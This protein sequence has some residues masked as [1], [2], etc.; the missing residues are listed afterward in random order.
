M[1]G[2]KYLSELVD[3]STF[4]KNK[5]NI[6]KAPTG[7]GK[8]YFALKYIPSLVNNALHQM[9][10]LIDTINGKEQILKNY[11][12]TTEPW[13]W[14]KGIARGEIWFEP[15]G[16]VVIM[17]YAKFGYIL[18]NAPDIHKQFDYI[19][20]DELHSLIKFQN[21]SPKPN[22]HSIAKRGLEAAVEND[23]TVVIALSA[24]PDPVKKNFKAPYIEVPI[25]SKELIQYE[26]HE[27]C[28]YSNLKEL[29]PT[30][31]PEDIGICY[32][33][34]ISKMIQV[35]EL[36]RSLG[37]SPIAIWSISNSDHP[38]T[39]E[40]LS[41]RTSI[42]NTFTIPPQYNLLII[43]SSSETS[44]KIKSKV[45]YVIVHSTNSDTQVQV[46]G[47]VNSDLVRIYLLR[48]GNPVNLVVPEEYLGTKLFVEDKKKLCEILNIWD[49]RGRLCKWNTI[50]KLLIDHD[51]EIKEGRTKNLRYA[52]ITQS[53]K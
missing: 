29:F 15:D 6:I 33:S 10:Y 28:R 13:G 49:E 39:E 52:V 5:L 11:N 42:L 16:R 34:H 32:V 19:I 44:L 14:W 8:T 47:R 17:T 2:T 20:C 35:E 1:T 36:A 37:F 22:C 27:V 3:C 41:V 38:M 7:S 45:D 40:Q 46:R 21:F 48:D 50:H 26:V 9:V 18:E 24:T 25:D 53:P 30:L 51:Y 12:A 23:S 43:N 4:E 31:K